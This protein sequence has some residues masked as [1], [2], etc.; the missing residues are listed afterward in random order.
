MILS[1]NTTAAVILISL[2]T[3][4]IRI[5]VSDADASRMHRDAAARARA[6]RIPHRYRMHPVSHP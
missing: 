6:R 5:P 4:T 2:F 1:M 3:D